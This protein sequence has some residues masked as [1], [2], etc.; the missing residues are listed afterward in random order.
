[1][2]ARGGR[3]PRRPRRG[4][5]VE[6][7]LRVGFRD[8]ARGTTASVEVPK[9]RP[10]GSVEAVR[11]SLTIPAGVDTGKK[12]R[13][14]GQGSPGP[15]GGPPGDLYVRV[16]VDDH[17]VFTRDGLDLGLTVPITVPEALRG[18]QVEVP[19]LDGSVKLKVPPGA[20]SG[21]RMRLRGKG[22][23]PAKGE[24]G[25]LYVTL[26]VVVP[27][28]GDAETR[29]RLARE[30]EALYRKDVREELKRRAR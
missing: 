12:L 10:D 1:M 26:E 14:A 11:L 9:Q 5:D 7:T 24:P 13:L 28:G 6:A 21:Q 2:F 19:T 22:I 20:Q 29:E 15:G 30:L 8:A 4:S 25:D 27:D 18:G 17:P 3:R 23:G 16:E